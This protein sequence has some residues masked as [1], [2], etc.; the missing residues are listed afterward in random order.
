[1]NRTS[2]EIVSFTLLNEPAPERAVVVDVL[3]R[4][5]D[6]CLVR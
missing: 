1:M 2:A 3:D 5:F 4:W 6:R